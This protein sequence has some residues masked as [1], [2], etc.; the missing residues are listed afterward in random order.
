MIGDNRKS[1]PLE[2]VAKMANSLVNGSELTIIGGVVTLR[3]RKLA[4]EKF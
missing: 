3:R 1:L 2:E 4:C